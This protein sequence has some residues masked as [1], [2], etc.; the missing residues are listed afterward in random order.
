[1]ATPP[2]FTAGQVLTAAQMNA[3]GLWLIGTTTW[4]SAAGTQSFDG[5]FTSDF[6]NYKVILNID[7][8]NNDVS[9]NGKLRASGTPVS[10]DYKWVNNQQ[11]PG[12]GALGVDGSNSGTAFSLGAVSSPNTICQFEIF[13]PQAAAI[14]VWSGT[15]DNIQ[16][17]FSNSIQWYEFKGHL[18]NTNAYDGMEFTVSAG[19][20]TGSASVYGYRA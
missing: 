4:S 5:R 19:T 14:T 2:V 11:Y 7:A 1:M 10:S 6:Q 8:S 18:N 15:T 9:L 16:G 17:A 12:I 20:F 13:R 3:V